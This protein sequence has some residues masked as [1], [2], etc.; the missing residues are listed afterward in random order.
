MPLTAPA[1]DPSKVSLLRLNFSAKQQSLDGGSG[2]SGGKTALKGDTS[3]R[4]D[5]GDV[6]MKSGDLAHAIQEF[7]SER[8]PRGW[9]NAGVCY[10]R[11]YCKHGG[12]HRLADA[13]DAFR[14]AIAGSGSAEMKSIAAKNALYALIISGK[15]R[16]AAAFMSEIKR[17]HPLSELIRACVE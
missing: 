10:A 14:M 11:L 15:D 1:T 8:T 16:D 6:L 7:D 17:S 12:V 5:K 9:N 3:S 4:F 13:I 2:D